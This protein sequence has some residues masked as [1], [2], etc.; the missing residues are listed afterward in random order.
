MNHKH[1]RTLLLG[2]VLGLAGGCSPE[3]PEGTQYYDRVIQPLLDRTCAGS[4]SGC[5]RANPNDPYQFAA[6]NL[7][8]TSFENIKKRP[9]LLRTY[10]SY[11][12]PFLLLKAVGET[13]D[14]QI[15]YGGANYASRIP[16]TGGSTLQVGSP[17]FVTLQLWLENGATRDGQKPL[18]VPVEGAG[19]CSTTVPS[20]FD[21]ASVTGTPEYAANGGS[22]FDGVQ[23]VLA[24]KGCNAQNCHGAPQ[25]DFYITCGTDATQRAFNFRQIWSFVDTPVDDS[26][27]LQRP[28]AGGVAHTGGAHFPTRDD[29]GYQ[30]LRTWAEA[31]GVLEFGE[32]D[33]ERF[34]RDRV[35]PILL[36]RGCATEGCHSPAAMN[37][38]KLRA[39]TLGFFSAVA[40]EKNY[41]LAKREF[42]AFESPDPR[43]GRIVAKNVFP[44]HGGIAHRGGALLESGTGADPASCGPYDPATASDFCTFLEWSNIE[45]LPDNRNGGATIPYVYVERSPTHVARA[46][47][48]TVFQPGS[49]LR[50]KD[51]DVTP[52][53]V[54][55]WAG[56]D[57]AS[58][59]EGPCA[60]TA[61]NVDVRGPDVKNDGRTVVFAMRT[62]AGDSFRL[63]TTD[64]VSGGCVALPAPPAGAHDLDPAFSP[65][66]TSI[67]FASTRAGG[68]SRRLNVA[69]TDLWRMNTDGSGLQ[70]ITFLSNSELSPAFMR[71]GRITMSTEKAD[72]ADPTA[73]FYQIAGRRLNWDLT[74]YHP[75]LAQRALSP[76]DPGDPS[77]E[78]PSVGYAQA[79]EIREGM[80]GDFLLILSNPDAVGGAGTLGIFNRSVGPFEAGRTDPGFLRA[81]TVPNGN[82]I[83][84][85]P[86]PAL[87]GQVLVSYAGPGNPTGASLRFEPA[88]QSPAG[89]NPTVLYTG[90]AGSIVEGVLALAYE[91]RH[92]YFNRRQL[93][94]GGAQDTTD[95]GHAIV[96]FPDAPMLA[97]LLAANLRRGRGV[98]AFRPADSLV[99]FDANMAP[100]GEA[101]L[102]EDGS[103]RI[104]VPSSVP[105][106]I[107]LRRGSTTIFQMT[108]EH[109][110]G[111]GERISLG[112]RESL[113]DNVCGGCHGSRSGVELD[114]A[115]TPDALTGASQSLSATA[116]PTPIGN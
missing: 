33:G 112:I 93:V 50:R 56:G 110:F 75:L 99:I 57:G 59:I 23:A 106:V 45:R 80:N 84:R 26:E 41:D 51:L 98:A 63:Y 85:S 107:G 52:T 101:P 111:P 30:T 32:T 76:I 61:A 66:G 92:L 13:S 1:R 90:A 115:V 116:D 109:Q 103:V 97:T 102:E 22:T 86:F 3:Q 96:H 104:R 72:P 81:L 46:A 24:D 18:P 77:A 7:D 68:M 71:E 17:G 105:V 36:A 70:Q 95:P 114:I 35:Q 91:E 83:Y 89:G 62:S 53:G 65:D 11:P 6:G 74:D 8:V 67:V 82:G 69:Q 48:P 14:L 64:L 37:D 5:H 27:F 42:M 55:S 12:A 38:F 40:L 58:L 19:A 16:H 43:R 28:V 25:S 34:F 78:N 21:P 113:F 100:L 2:A 60:V 108:E 4:V 31:V 49:N 88:L 9:D 73:G 44:S 10:G 47:D 94:F 39:G 29:G 20:D 54:L 15:V 79:T 87:D